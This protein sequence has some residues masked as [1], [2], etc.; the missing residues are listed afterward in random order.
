MGKHVAEMLGAYLALRGRETSKNFLP[1]FH[2]GENML[3]TLLC[4]VALMFG[5]HGSGSELVF[6][7]HESVTSGINPDIQE[8]ID[9]L[10]A[11]GEEKGWLRYI[12]VPAFERGCVGMGDLE[13]VVAAVAVIVFS[14]VITGLETG[15]AKVT[16]G[17]GPARLDTDSVMLACD[18]LAAI[19]Y[20]FLAERVEFN[21]ADRHSLYL[22]LKLLDEI[23]TGTQLRDSD[24][25]M[26]DERGRFQAKVAGEAFFAQPCEETGEIDGALAGVEIAALSVDEGMAVGIFDVNMMYAVIFP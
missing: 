1:F 2:K 3:E 8:K 5:E 14:E 9:L 19:A 17:K 16:G 15:V 24:D 21:N 6:V 22:P 20:F 23:E 13:D 18:D 12:A 11:V 10:D 26:L 7:E 25:T 4:L